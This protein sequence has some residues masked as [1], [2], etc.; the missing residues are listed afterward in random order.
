MVGSTAYTYGIN[1]TAWWFQWWAFLIYFV[2][3]SAVVFTFDRIQRARLIKKEREVAR[4]REAELRAETADARSKAAE[5]QTRMLEIEN[6][7]KAS[8]LEK[9]RELEKAYYELKEAQDQLIQ[10][11]KMASLGRMSAGIAHEIKNPL[12]FHQQLRRSFQRSRCRSE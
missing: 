10:A 12:N 6:E 7:R 1:L 3:M 2:V 11:E 4:L 8:E 5:A 9:A